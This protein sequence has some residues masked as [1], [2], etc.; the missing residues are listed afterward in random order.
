MQ[1]VEGEMTKLD[2]LLDELKYARQM[3]GRKRQGFLPQGAM[4]M[5]SAGS[6]GKDQDTDE[7]ERVKAEIKGVKGVLLS[8]RSFPSTSRPAS[9]R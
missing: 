6:D 3:Y 1:G 7:I 8:A 9:A 2:S 5:G 4:W